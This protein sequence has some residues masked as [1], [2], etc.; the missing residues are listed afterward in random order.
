MKVRLIWI[1]PDAERLIAYCARVSNPENQDNPNYT[2]LI[3]YCIDNHHWSILET[4]NMC[5]E[6]QTSRAISAQ[7]LRHRSFSFQEFSQRYAKVQEIEPFEL[8][9]QATTNRQSSTEVFDPIIYEYND[10]CLELGSVAVADHLAYSQDLYNQ[11][12]EKGVA[13]E[14]ARMILPM[15]SSTTLY[16]NGTV[17]SWIHY[18]EIRDEEHAQ[19]EHQLIAKEIKKILCLNLPITA[20]ALGW[21][22]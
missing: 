4:A 20:E 12:V 9:K 22:T 18:L 1:T 6:I 3:K 17:R 13:K 14:C 15:A 8:R 10:G 7:V 2:K 19:L 21:T 5:I 16:M 11:L